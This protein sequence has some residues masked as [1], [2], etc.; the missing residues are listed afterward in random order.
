[1]ILNYKEYG[2]DRHQAVFFLHGLL[3]NADNWAST[4]RELAKAGLRCI[5]VDQRN[6][7]SSP[8][9]SQ[10]SFPLMAEDLV[11]LADTLN[12]DH[13]SIVGHSMGGKT[14]METALRFPERVKSIVVADIAPVEYKP[15]YTDYISSL[16]N[17]SLDGVTKRSDVGAELEKYVPDR[18]LRL[19]F[20]TNLRKNED[21]KFQWR[22][23]IDGITDNYGNIWKAIDGGRQFDGP[24]LFLKG[25]DSDFILE[26]YYPLMKDLF[27]RHTVEIIDGSGHWV[28]TERP[29]IFRRL[30]Q[31]FLV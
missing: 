17:I 29:E 15:A 7:G 6:H 1:M 23:N 24:V 3:G 21:G 26:K 11:R 30:V 22:I 2:T 25:S 14:A 10:M 16:K 19:F 9:S 28:H 13:F 4:S 8:H 20:L 27:P 5:A 18:N 12:I 31:D